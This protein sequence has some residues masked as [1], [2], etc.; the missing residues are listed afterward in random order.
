MREIKEWLYGQ[1]CEQPCKQDENGGETHVMK[2]L[3]PLTASDQ[4]NPRKYLTNGYFKVK[5]DEHHQFRVKRRKFEC[6]KP[7]QE[8]TGSKIFE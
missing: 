1:L 5:G 3:Y 7:D 2:H 4:R 6:S 8:L